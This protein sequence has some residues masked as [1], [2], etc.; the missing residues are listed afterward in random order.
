VIHHGARHVAGHCVGRLAWEHRQRSSPGSFAADRMQVGLIGS[1]RRVAAV[2]A[3]NW[4]TAQPAG[5]SGMVQVRRL[6]EYMLISSFLCY[7]SR[8]GLNMSAFTYD[9]VRAMAMGYLK[10]LCAL[11]SLEAAAAQAQVGAQARQ[12]LFRTAQLK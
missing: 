12:P 3:V 2:V 10:E 8:C 11:S 9:A 7:N 5:G 6:V 4:R 1:S